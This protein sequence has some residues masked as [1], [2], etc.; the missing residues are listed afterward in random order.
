MVFDSARVS[1]DVDGAERLKLEQRR[2]PQSD[3]C[4]A[5]VRRKV[6]LSENAGGELW[7]ETNDVKVE[8]WRGIEQDVVL[9]W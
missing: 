5:R 7:R 9:P 3:S 6:V 1:A 2:L 4:R 8:V